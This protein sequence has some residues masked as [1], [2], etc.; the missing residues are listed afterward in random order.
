MEA[1]VRLPV[2]SAV[3]G[4]IVFRDEGIGVIIHEK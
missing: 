2:I 4:N 3:R 1:V